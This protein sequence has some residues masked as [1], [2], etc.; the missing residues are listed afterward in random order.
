LSWNGLNFDSVTFLCEVTWGA[1]EELWLGG[2]D[3]DANGAGQLVSRFPVLRV[4]DLDG[5]ELG[6]GGVR[7]LCGG[8]WAHLED[9][10]LG[11]A[12]IEHPVLP[13]FTPVSSRLH[14]SQY[15]LGNSNAL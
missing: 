11:R 13:E 7:A 12:T 1:L 14:A 3:I 10:R 2:N 5:N 9:L 4:L 6:D 8:T 15:Q